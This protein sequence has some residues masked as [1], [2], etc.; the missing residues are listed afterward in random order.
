MSEGIKTVIYPVKDLAAAKQIFG[1]LA[2]VEPYSDEAY[3]VGFKVDGQDVGLDPKGHDKG[4]IGPVGYWHVDDIDKTLAALTD[5]GA[6]VQ[7][8]VRKVG[9]NR[10]VATVTDPDGNPIALLQD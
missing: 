9:G 4:M 10:R 7:D 1:Q 5:A 6:T 3:Y 8:P 2:R